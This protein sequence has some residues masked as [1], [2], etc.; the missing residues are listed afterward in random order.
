MLACPRSTCQCKAAS[1]CHGT[2]S[3]SATEDNLIG[4]S[5][6]PSAA[7]ERDDAIHSLES[8]QAALEVLYARL[9][10]AQMEQSATMAGGSWSAK[11]LVGHVAAWEELALQTI[12]AWRTGQPLPTDGEWPG[13]DAFNARVQERTCGQLLLDVRQHAAAT[14]GALVRAIQSLTGEE[15]RSS[16]GDNTL[17][18]TLGRI[19]GGPAGTFRHVFDH[20]DDLKAFVDSMH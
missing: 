20:L 1:I 17:G 8:G 6:Y 14:H 7:T 11:D 18:D 4:V 19:T 16:R 12:G 10:D 9:S 2:R 3:L 13:T 15:W 5:S